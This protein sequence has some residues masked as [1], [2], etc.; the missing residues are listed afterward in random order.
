MKN[1]K[2]KFSAILLL[3]FAFILI[4]YFYN[5][6][7]YTTEYSKEDAIKKFYLSYENKDLILYNSIV[8]NELKITKED[9]L[10]QRNLLYSDLL[11]FNLIEVKENLD[12]SITTLNG[13]SYK[14][15]NIAEFTITYE[16]D[17]DKNIFGTAGEGK[18]TVRKILVRQDSNSPWLIA[19]Q[20]DGQGY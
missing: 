11:S 7:T 6:T 9:D 1:S 4:F 10:K 16:I 3:I 17:F 12:S 20:I 8:I 14:K 13:I 5:K 18:Q 2:Y 19:G 15:E